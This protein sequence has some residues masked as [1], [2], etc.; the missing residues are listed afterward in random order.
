[1]SIETV[2]RQPRFL[3]LYHLGEA[4]ADDIDDYIEQWHAGAGPDRHVEL[5][6][7]LGMT[8]PHYVRWGSRNELPTAY[9]HRHARW[10]ASLMRVNHHEM[11]VQVHPPGRCRPVCPIHW[12]SNHPLAGAVKWWDCLEGVMRRICGHGYDH[13]DPDDQQVRLHP[14]L[15]EHDCDGCCTA[16]V[17]DGG[18]VQP[19]AIGGP[20]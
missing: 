12:P 18:L 1:M 17:I 2:A 16:T 10:D 20:A 6:V 11:M 14:V 9:E 8:W 7:A 5:H 19:R 13:P 3:V 4:D 15:S